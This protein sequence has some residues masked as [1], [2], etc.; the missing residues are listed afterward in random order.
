MQHQFP[1][2]EYSFGM[3]ISKDRLPTAQQSKRNRAL[4]NIKM[5][6]RRDA[7]IEDLYTL[8]HDNETI[9]SHLDHESQGF[10][11]YLANSQNEVLMKIYQNY[12]RN[13]NLDA[14]VEELENL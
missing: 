10:A 4:T 11:K 8:I 13:I 2:N 1:K 6:E 9:N 3:Q 12:C 14:F 7:D 5:Q